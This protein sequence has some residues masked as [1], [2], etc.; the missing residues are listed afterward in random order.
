VSRAFAIVA[1]LALALVWF[2]GL[3]HRKLVRADES[4]Y[5]EIPREMVASG[6]WLTPRL[7][8]FKYF[9]KP[10]LQYWATATAFEAF[11]VDEWTV[12]LWPALTGFAGI[13]LVFFA[14]ARCFGREVGLYASAALAGSL[15]YA[16]LGH[17]TTLDMGVTLFLSAAVFAFVVAQLDATPEPER[18]RWMLAAW[19]AAAAAVLSKGL[20][21]LVLPGGAFVLYLLLRRDWG[22]V[23]RLYLVRGAALFF[24]VAAPW[25]VAVSL[26]NPEFA[27][28]FFIH[29]HFERFLTKVHDR[30]EPAWYFLPVL[31]AGIMPWLASFAAGLWQAA[32]EREPTRFRPLLFLLLWCATVFVFFSASSSKLASYILPLFPAAAL[33]IGR[34]L[35]QASRALLVGQAILAALVGAACA[36]LAPR[37]PH[38]GVTR[39]P[40]ELLVAYAPWLVAAG[41]ALFGFAAAS[42]ALAWRGRRTASVLAL[43]TAGLAF[44]QLALVGRETLSPAYS[45]YHAIERA[46][47]ALMREAPGSGRP[48]ARPFSDAPFY[49]VDA[50]DH[51]LPFYLERTVTMVASRDEL[52]PS[53]AWEPEKFVADVPRFVELWRAAPRAYAVFRP[54]AFAQLRERYALQ[55]TVL[56]ED[57][58]HVIVQKP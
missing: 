4:R 16:A 35:A 41:T 10:P 45:A 39:V 51:T 20:I 14:G 47:A 5:G 2:S 33:L 58:D 13:L 29:E 53:I 30:Y 54:A 44:M 17:F 42:A 32:R 22:L 25:F 26:A 46:R 27:R 23:K 31:A 52:S 12:R 34:Q 56:A 36:L 37:I 49:V 3:D 21:G 55:G 9:E 6:D 50:Y 19:A 28:F 24:A 11:G 38:L 57:L 48:P 8:G 18:R 15:L 1:V 43:A 40:A 7:N